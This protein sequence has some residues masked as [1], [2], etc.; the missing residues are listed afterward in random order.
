[1]KC[2]L[3]IS[4]FLAEFLNH[5]IALI[6]K[7]LIRTDFLS[8]PKFSY[9]KV[10]FLNPYRK[11]STKSGITASAPSDSNNSTKLLLAVGE[12]LTRIS[13][14]IPT[15][16]FLISFTGMT[17]NS[18]TIFFMFFLK[19]LIPNLLS[20]SSLHNLYSHFLCKASVSPSFTS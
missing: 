3:S 10:A 1:M 20:A 7:L 2:L 16:G 8:K 5:S 18:S 13:P 11:K 14:T 6:P 12:N 17:S 15:L 4:A 9:L 19:R